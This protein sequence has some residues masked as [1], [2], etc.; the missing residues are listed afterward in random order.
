MGAGSQR[1]HRQGTGLVAVGRSSADSGIARGRVWSGGDPS[2]GTTIASVSYGLTAPDAG[3]FWPVYTRQILRRRFHLV[4][5]LGDV[6]ER[7]AEML[8]NSPDQ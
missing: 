5:S 1:S 7:A 4:S 2:R 3:L 8:Y 6:A